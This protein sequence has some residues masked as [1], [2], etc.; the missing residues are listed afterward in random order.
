MTITEPQSREIANLPRLAELM[1]AA[2]LDVL[3]ASTPENVLYLTSMYS[4]SHWFIA[5]V[6]CYAVVE[7]DRLDEPKLVYP[8]GD[9]D[10]A[11]ESGVQDLDLFAYGQ[12]FVLP[13]RADVNLPADEAALSRLAQAEPFGAPAEALAAALGA[14]GSKPSRIGVDARG[15]SDGAR[16]AVEAFASRAGAS[17][18]T[19]GGDVLLSARMVKTQEEIRR[20]TYAAH[21]TEDAMQHV[22]DNAREGMTETEAKRIF[23]EFLVKRDVEPRLT[24]LTFGGHS[25]FPS[26]IPGERALKSGDIIRF[27][28]GGV[29]QNYWSD[30]SR[31][32]VFGEPTERMT[33]YYRA[34]LLGEDACLAAA[35]PGVTASSVFEAAVEVVRNEGIPH[36][37]RQHVGHGIGLNVY[38]PPILKAGNDTELLPG[39]VLNVETPYYEVGFGGLQVEDLIVITEDGC[40]ML[41]RTSREFRRV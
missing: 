3:V 29:Y 37:R 7:R 27:D 34:L 12:F 28:V 35:G 17:V 33:A 39:M 31:V 32:A 38:D 14:V 19:S 25:A 23:H 11:V 40:E 6:E 21:V 10:L 30:L 15:L 18:E 9:S 36:Y 13:P 26:G 4:L 2:G 22:L 20:L 5:G 16:S 1:D 8:I 41:T 24:V